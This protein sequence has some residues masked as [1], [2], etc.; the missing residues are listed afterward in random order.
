MDTTLIQIMLLHIIVSRLNPIVSKFV[1]PS[2]ASPIPLF[3]LISSH[4][5]MDQYLLIPFLVGWTSIYQLFWCSL[6]AR[7]LTH[8][9]VGLCGITRKCHGIWFC[10]PSFLGL[11]VLEVVRGEAAGEPVPK[12]RETW[13]GSLGLCDRLEGE[14]GGDDAFV[15]PAMKAWSAWQVTEHKTTATTR[16]NGR[17]SYHSGYTSSP[18]TRTYR[19]VSRLAEKISAPLVPERFQWPVGVLL[20]FGLVAKNW[21]V[22]TGEKKLLGASCPTLGKVS[23]V[24]PWSQP[25]KPSTNSAELLCGLASGLLALDLPQVLLSTGHHWTCSGMIGWLGMVLPEKLNGAQLQNQLRQAAGSS[26]GSSRWVTSRTP[27]VWPWCLHRLHGWCSCPKRPPCWLLGDRKLA[28]GPGIQPSK[29]DR[30]IDR[31]IYIIYILYITWFNQ[32][33]AR[34][35]P[36]INKC[37]A[38]MLRAHG[39]LHICASSTAWTQN[40][41]EN[42]ELQILSNITI[43]LQSVAW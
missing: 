27:P 23:Q 25:L 37:C 39:S 6:G 34:F 13:L 18:R 19:D 24:R 26:A 30:W 32:D 4:M 12:L 21:M 35:I 14:R 5:A 42:A 28:L 2:L 17:E 9:H 11:G 43:L 7:V 40:K 1:F 10:P 33:M 15:W 38:Q 36:Y 8:P 3:W 29:I 22:K 41:E 31:Y 20:F 16:R